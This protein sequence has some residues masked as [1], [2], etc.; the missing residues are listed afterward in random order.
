MALNFPGNPQTGDTYTEDSTT[1]QWDGTAWNVVSNDT[2]RNIFTN[3]SADNGAASPTLLNDTLQIIGSGSVTTS[4]ENK[5]LTI[6]S[7]GAGDISNAFVTLVS[8]DGTFDVG[9]A[10]EL[11]VAGGTN[12]STQVVTDSEQVTL[13]LDPFEISFLSNVSDAAPTSGQ[14]LKWDGSQWAPAADIASGGAG[15]DADTLDGFD[16]TYYLDYTNFTNTPSVLT[17]TSLSIGNENA[18]S[19]DGAISYDNTTGTFRYTPPDLSSYL[20]SVAFSDLTST[21]TTIAGYGITDALELGTTSTTALAGDTSIPSTLTDLGISDGS[22]GQ[23]LTTD[24]TGN[25]TFT[26]VSGGGSSDFLS[27]TDTPSSFGSAGQVVVVN[28]TADGL[29]FSTAG[30]GGEVNQNAFSNIAVSGQSTIEADSSTDTLNFVNG[31]N[32]A[33]TTN[34]TSDTITISAETSF[35]DLTD[36]T[37]A[38]VS[39]DKIYEPAIAMLRVDNDGASAYT[40]NSHYTGNNPTIYAISGTTIAFDL[41]GISGHPFE[42][43]DSLGNAFNTGLVH[44]SSS[45]MVSTGSNA[46]GQDSGTLYWRIP[47]TTTSPPNFR[48]QCQLHASMVG[49]ITIKDLSA[50]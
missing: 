6:N 22:S 32:I 15:L 40:F 30:S 42:I 10:G 18:A 38:S 25:F 2:N 46:Q 5:T 47:E 36:A 49:A 48:Y 3:F 11:R 7:E 12:I 19:G 34:P 43:Q 26:T 37:T 8:D 1:W 28:S 45:G 44:V 31:S 13:D 4:I 33:I 39:I 41:D 29:E 21:P 17:L 50:L 24:G 27:L 16:S 23:V 9:S 14:V 35:A 20:T